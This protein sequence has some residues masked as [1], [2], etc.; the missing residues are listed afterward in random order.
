MHIKYLLCTSTFESTDSFYFCMALGSSFYGVV[1]I[2]VLEMK[3]CDE[4][5]LVNLSEMNSYVEIKL[6]K[7][8]ARNHDLDLRS[9][10][11]EG[12]F[13]PPHCAL[14]SPDAPTQPSIQVFRGNEVT[15]N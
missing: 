13:V 9:L 1:L 10:G 15:T 8:D 7:I 5:F 2:N 11:C 3:S 14:T 12:R 6:N 4:V